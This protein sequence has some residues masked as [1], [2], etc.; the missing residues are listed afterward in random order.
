MK[1]HTKKLTT[2]GAKW[3]CLESLLEERWSAATFGAKHHLPASIC[4]PQ[5]SLLKH[6]DKSRGVL[7]VAAEAEV[8]IC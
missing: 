8:K 4:R 1:V 6:H 5:V 7:K 3:Q 2:T